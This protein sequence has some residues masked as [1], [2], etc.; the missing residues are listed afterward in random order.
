[1]PSAKPRAKKASRTRSYHHGNLR[2]ALIRASFALIARDG[3]GALT[4][5]KVAKM[6]GVTHAAPYAH[7]VD[8]EDLIAALKQE[9][10]TELKRQVEAILGSQA[11]PDRALLV[12]AA[13]AYVRFALDSPA[14]FQVMFR[15]PLPTDRPQTGHDFVRPGQEIFA[16]LEKAFA[17]LSPQDEATRKR[18]ALMGWAMIHG[19]VSLRID[20]P[21]SHI[22]PA[23]EPPEAF[24][25]LASECVNR[26]L[27][28]FGI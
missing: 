14:M 15:N 5:R 27:A 25:A 16:L 18:N 3:V 24:Q 4:L 17:A 8:K 12:K 28:L 19:L 7:F 1:M 20:G 6:A 13:G 23:S 10:F 11:A 2:S 26:L 9:G 22:V 21:L